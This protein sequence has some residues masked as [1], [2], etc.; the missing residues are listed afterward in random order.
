MCIFVVHT[1]AL[2][3]V[4]GYRDFFRQDWLDQ[5]LSWQ[6]QPR[7]CWGEQLPSSTGEINTG[8]LK[9]IGEESLENNMLAAL[10]YRLE[11]LDCS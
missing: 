6:W 5:I 8:K 1:E 7:G 2:C 4:L 11:W 3:G 10:S 9:S